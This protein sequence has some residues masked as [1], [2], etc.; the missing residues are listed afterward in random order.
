VPDKEQWAT[1]SA[2]LHFILGVG[3][4]NAAN[5]EFARTQGLDRG[6]FLDAIATM[7]SLLDPQEY[8]FKGIPRSA[9][10]GRSSLIS[11]SCEL[12][13]EKSSKGFGVPNAVRTVL[14]P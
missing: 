9:A 13:A 3:G 6:D 7:W 5:G 10:E 11:A 4:Q 8:P 14:P 12:E 1:V 2:L